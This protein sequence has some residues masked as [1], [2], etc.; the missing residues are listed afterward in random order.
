MAINHFALL[1]Q[2]NARRHKNFW[3]GSKMWQDYFMSL[4]GHLIYSLL[5]R[6]FYGKSIVYNSCH[7]NY[8]LA[9]RDVRI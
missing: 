7:T 4:S 3:S 9:V 2:R 6:F 5:K 1:S 8:W